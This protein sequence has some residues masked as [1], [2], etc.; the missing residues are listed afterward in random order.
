M[1]D[2]KSRCHIHQGDLVR[3]VLGR[4]QIL[5]HVFFDYLPRYKD[6]D[7]SGEDSERRRAALKACPVA[8]QVIS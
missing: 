1:D 2:T 5:S 6:W 4:L 8:N 3:T 7:F